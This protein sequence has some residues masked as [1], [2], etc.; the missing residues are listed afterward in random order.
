M[1][2]LLL[3]Y[4]QE[5]DLQKMDP[6]KIG[7]M[8]A[9]YATY[10][11]SLKKAGVWLGGERLKPSSTASSVRVADGKTTV[12]NGPYAETREQL[13]GY[14]MIDAPDDATAQSWAARCPG[15]ATGTMEVR[16]VWQLAS[17]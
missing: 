1:Q 11:E 6:A 14:Y 9:A 3:I 17:A 2:Y 4:G 15:A 7:Q 5:A 12:L 8:S 16:Q 13:A 10:T